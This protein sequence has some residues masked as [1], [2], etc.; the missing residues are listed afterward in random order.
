M[1]SELLTTRDGIEIKVDGLHLGLTYAGLLDGLPNA[2]V[3]LEIV[4]YFKRSLTDVWGKRPTLVVWPLGQDPNTI[5]R[6][7]DWTCA[8]WASSSF[9]D[10]A[11]GDGTELI[12]VWFEPGIDHTPVLEL[13]AAIVRH[14]EWRVH[15]QG[16]RF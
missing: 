2:S 16:W 10:D 9:A 15:A 4:D 14:V 13:A 3:N 6:L 12:V 11:D 1:S 7:P 8:L 5:E